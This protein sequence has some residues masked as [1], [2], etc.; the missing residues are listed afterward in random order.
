[1]NSLGIEQYISTIKQKD[2]CM[3][4]YG[5]NIYSNLWYVCNKNKICITFTPRGGFSI[6]FQ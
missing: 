3:T 1:M 6:A 2:L 4:T 5:H